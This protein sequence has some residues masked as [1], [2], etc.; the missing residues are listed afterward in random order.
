[1][2]ITGLRSHHFKRPARWRPTALAMGGLALI[3]T[4]CGTTA[5]A[6]A[7]AKK[8]PLI[9]YAAEG[10]DANTV[11]AFQARTG[12][13]TQLVDDST[14][15]LLAKIQAEANNP[16]W[17][18]LWVDGDEAFAALDKQHYL[19]RGFEPTVAWTA[20]ALRVLPADHSY[21]PTGFTAMP[22]VVYNRQVVST[23][24]TTWQQLLEPQWKNAVGMN[25]PAVS[26]PTYPFVAGM[27]QYLGGVTKGES[28]FEQL[29]ANGLKIYPTNKPTLAALIQGQIKLA[30]VQNSAGIGAAFQDR[31][32]KLAYLD[33]VTL[34]PSIIGIDGRAS[35]QEQAE[36]KQF[37]D[38]V[39]SS[40][41]Q[42]QRLIGDPHGDSLF[43]PVVK[44][45]PQLAAVP[46]FSSIPY[47]ILNAYT[48][49]PREATID[50]W[51]SN[52]IVA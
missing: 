4:G 24:P 27:M 33:P 52:N 38:F 20:A 7:S 25:N 23:P 3:L 46:P 18:L 43:W 15:P 44:G 34:L 45:Y 30:L 22:A 35:A 40:A 5:A 13:P 31:S 42:H 14:G 37:V 47:Q 21:V 49:G 39:F 17:G 36:A 8:V 19:L 16:Q 32:L 6:H 50:E 1:M 2:R 9:V 12:I 10:Y 41:G 26:G 29:K 51:F 11:A 48:W 28:Y